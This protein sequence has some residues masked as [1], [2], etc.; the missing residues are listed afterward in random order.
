MYLFHDH[1]TLFFADNF[2][3]ECQITIKFLVFTQF[4]S[5]PEIILRSHRVDRGEND[6]LSLNS[7]LHKNYNS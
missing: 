1:V 4:F 5:D 7:V 6:E 3:T 2:S